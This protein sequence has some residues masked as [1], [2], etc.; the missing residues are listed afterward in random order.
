M[1]GVGKEPH[2][3]SLLLFAFSGL[4]HFFLFMEIVPAFP[5]QYCCMNVFGEFAWGCFGAQWL[6]LPVRLGVENT[7]GSFSVCTPLI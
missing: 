3:Q 5:F 1:I 7:W 4:I 2:R 6:T